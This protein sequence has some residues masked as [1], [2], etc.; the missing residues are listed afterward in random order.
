MAE[1]IQ[2]TEKSRLEQIEYAY[3]Q[4][5][6]FIRMGNPDLFNDSR[7]PPDI[8]TLTNFELP[9]GVSD[10]MVKPLLRILAS[11]AQIAKW[12]PLLQSAR[13]FGAY[14]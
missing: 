5:A 10:V 7:F 1:A 11:D 13:I 4:R 3:K 14:A 8:I 6:K 12:M 2:F 9:G